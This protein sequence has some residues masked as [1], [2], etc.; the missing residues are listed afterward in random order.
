MSYPSDLRRT[1]RTNSTKPLERARVEIGFMPIACASSLICAEATGIFERNGLE[2]QL[3]RASAWAEIRD[4]MLTGQIDAA[5]MLFPAALAA[6]A[7][8]PPARTCWRVA[9]IGNVNGQALTLSPRFA[10]FREARSLRGLRLGVPHDYSIHNYLLRHFLAAGGIDPDREVQ[11]KVLPPSD[12]I[13]GLRSNRIDGFL[14]PEP[15]NQLAVDA[16][17]GFLFRLSKEIWQGHPC[18]SFVVDRAFTEACPK[19]F[20]ILHRSLVESAV[21]AS[22]P[23]NRKAMTEYLSHSRYLDQPSEILAEV[24]GPSFRD[25]LGDTCHAMDR[26]DFDPLPRG[27]A[28]IWILDQMRRWNHIPFETDVSLIANQVCMTE[29]CAHHLASVDESYASSFGTYEAPPPSQKP[30]NLT[31]SAISESRV[32]KAPPVRGTA[33]GSGEA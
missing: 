9:V 8:V 33:A 6:A 21:F 17:I 25:G 14:G 19:S 30:L 26:I 5:H 4:W 12:L 18:C 29:E 23:A 11:I 22:A 2:V 31:R 10:H 7:G 13:D 32:Y 15:F 1:E 24:L 16:G 27:E 20:S 3:R 28:A